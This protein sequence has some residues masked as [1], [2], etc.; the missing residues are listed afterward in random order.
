MINTGT[1]NIDEVLRELGTILHDAEEQS[2]P[3]GL[4]AALY[5]KVTQRVKEGIENGRFQDG[6]RMEVLDVIFANR[7]LEAYVQYHAAQPCTQSWRVAF[8]AAKRKDLLLLQHLFL[9]INAHINLDLGVAA[10]QVAPGEQLPNLEHDF[11]EINALLGEM[12]DEVQDRIRIV[13]PLMGVLDM[14]SG[15]DERFAQ[16]SLNAARKHAW[17]V[18]ELLSTLS[19]HRRAAAI[20]NIDGYVVKLNDLIVKPGSFK[21]FLFRIVALFEDNNI[22]TVIRTLRF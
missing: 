18:A 15:K 19:G 5:Y 10:A 3:I 22:T 9:G 20:E 7:F 2:N 4:F 12:I 14:L 21:Q 11:L 16:F 17:T 8:E 6:D 1:K 13:S